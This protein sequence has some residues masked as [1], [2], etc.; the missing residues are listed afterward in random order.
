MLSN[1]PYLLRAFHE[2]IVD[3]GCTPIIVIDA[4]NPRCKIPKDFIEGG[5]IVFNVSSDA[6]R[7]L[8]ITN[9]CVEF[10]ASFSGVIHMI[11]APINGILAIYAEENGEGLFFDAE[12]EA[13]S[14]SMINTS[15]IPPLNHETKANE[16]VVKA[17][18]FLTLIE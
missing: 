1:K 10:K 2:W 15:S 12:D 9:E 7:D 11:Y 5:E 17:K 8:K 14:D 4:L 13:S 3:S 6:I 16:A 18:P